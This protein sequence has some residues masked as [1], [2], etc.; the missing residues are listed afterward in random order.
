M[1]ISREIADR[2]KLVKLSSVTMK[3]VET[4]GRIVAGNP[5]IFD[6]FDKDAVHQWVAQAYKE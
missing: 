4:A 5:D 3:D 6:C 2:V 1:D